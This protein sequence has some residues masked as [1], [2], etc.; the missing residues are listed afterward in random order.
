[1]L[2]QYSLSLDCVIFWGRSIEKKKD[3][4]SVLLSKLSFCIS[5]IYVTFSLVH[6]FPSSLADSLLEVIASS[7]QMNHT[8]TSSDITQLFFNYGVWTFFEK[9][10]MM[11][12][13]QQH[14]WQTYQFFFAILTLKILQV[15]YVLI[16]HCIMEIRWLNLLP[17]SLHNSQILAMQ[18]GSK[19]EV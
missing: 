2:S 13:T 5:F 9:S 3:A 15:I 7:D 16:L 1:M 14:I 18:S 6:Q 8:V 10:G 17:T 12:K 4:S 19:S 11:Y